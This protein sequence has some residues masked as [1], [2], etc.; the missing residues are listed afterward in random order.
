MSVVQRLSGGKEEKITAHHAHH[1]KI[2][3]MHYV[4]FILGLWLMT[5]VTTFNYQ[6]PL[7]MWNDLVCGALIVIFSLLSV[8]PDRLWSP[9]LTVMTGLWLNIAPLFFWATDA[10]IYNNDT[11]I[12]VL[13]IT[14]A[15]VA[16][17]IPGIR[18]IEED[19][20]DKPPGWTINPSSWLQRAPIIFLGW[21]GFFA[22]RYLTSYQLGYI[23]T[24]WD[25]FFDK[26]T[27]DVLNSEVS[28]AWPVSDA[29]LGAFS[30]MLD[31]MMGYLGGQKRW[32]TMPW[33]VILFGILIIPLG[34]VSITLI[35]L[36]PVAV[37]AWCSVCLFTAFVM[38][39]M[40]PCTF[41]EV[42][43]SV[44][45]LKN[46]KKE[47]KPFW[48][49]FWLGGTVTDIVPSQAP[50]DFT[51]PVW[52]TVK[53]ILSEVSLPWNLVASMAIGIWLIVSPSFL[54]YTKQ[55]TDNNHLTGALIFTF[56]IIATGEIVRTARFINIL[57]GSWMIAAPFI[58]ESS[59]GASWNSWV[60]GALLIILSFRKG[61]ISYS[62]GTFN[63]YIV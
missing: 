42:F 44:W 31:A 56:S 52:R 26:G 1:R 61:R 50:Y 14:F 21:I 22:S 5:G 59:A 55:M 38:L 41:D 10:A 34:A 29:G 49:T 7:L 37:G 11:L 6:D 63:R 39:I 45:F 62:F 57:F 33:V 20:P 60:C 43:A 3:W 25:P 13:V 46:A 32:R 27:E 15:M 24:A 4:N 23:D 35:I 54:E 8:D 18:L 30:Y 9:W 36:Q 2:V 40:I 47:G 17:G 48:R 53:K 16:P 12:G 28:K 19:G 51:T 58:L